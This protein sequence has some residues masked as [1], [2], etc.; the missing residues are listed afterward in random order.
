MPKIVLTGGSCGG[1]TTIMTE[2]KKVFPDAIFIPEAAT[3]ILSSG[4]FAYPEMSLEEKWEFQKAILILQEAME[5]SF[6]ILS[7]PT[8]VIVCE[9]GLLDPSA[10]VPGGVDIF[11]QHFNLDKQTIFNRYDEVVHLESV[12]TGAPEAYNNITNPFRHETLEEAREH[13]YALRAVWQG[14]PHYHFVSCKNGMEG[15]IRY[16]KKLIQKLM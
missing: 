1:R 8:T 2:L 7:L 14:H 9:R 12:A 6:E 11:C 10:Y 15:K 4:P 16:V 3:I 5:E 13:E